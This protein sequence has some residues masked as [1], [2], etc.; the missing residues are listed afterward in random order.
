MKDAGKNEQQ[1]YLGTQAGTTRAC[2]Q[3]NEACNASALA[4]IRRE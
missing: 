2:T 3:D 4:D 1:V